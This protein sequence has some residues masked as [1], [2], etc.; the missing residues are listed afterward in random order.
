MPDHSTGL[1]LILNACEGVLQIAVTDDEKPLCF[2]QWHLPQKGAEILADALEEICRRLDIKMKQIRRIGC[3]AGPGSFTG[4]RLVLSTAAAIRRAGKAQ[5]ASLDYLQALATSAA[6]RRD[7]LYPAKIYVLTHARRNLAHFQCFT[8]F[9]P[10]IP[11]QPIAPVELI[12]PGEALRRIAGEPCLVCGSALG[13]YPDLFAL[14]VT[15]QGP[16]QAP[17][18]RLMANLVN[19]DLSA[20]CLLARHGDYLPIDVEPKYVR[21]CDALDNLAEEEEGKEKASAVEEILRK[22]PQS[23]I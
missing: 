3:F 10:Q 22:K 16:V 7:A 21:S 18:A 5:L 2:E 4:I 23:D 6:I 19:P 1:E 20:L 11:A 9:G 8:S 15:G 12:A 13:R 14:P 17:D